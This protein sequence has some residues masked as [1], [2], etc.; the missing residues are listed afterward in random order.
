M[1][2]LLTLSILVTTLWSC[3]PSD[4]YQTKT[5]EEDGYTYEYVEAD[6][7]NTRI[8]T[9]D[10]GL[11]VYLSHYADAPRIQVYT[12][13]KAGGKNDPAENTGLAHYLEH[14]MFK[15]NNKFGTV[16][17]EEEVVM[18]DSIEAMFNHYATLTDSDERKAYY[19]KIDNYSNEAAKYAIPNEYDKMMALIGGKGL[20]AYTSND[21]TV[22]TVDIPSNELGRFLEIEG[23]RFRKIV[24]RL[25]HTELETVYEEKNRSLDS[26]FR[27]VYEALLSGLYKEHPYGTQTVIGTINHLKNPSIT[28][29]KKYF[30]TYYRP[31][32]VAI[33][34][35]GD[36]DYSETIIL[37][38]KNFGDWESN[39]DLPVWNKIEEDPITEPRI[40]EVYGPDAE[41]LQMGFRFNGTNSD[42]YIKV[43]LTDM[44]LNNAEAGL[45]DLNLKQKQT[46]LNAGSYVNNMNDYSIHTIYG[47]AKQ[48][49]SLEEVRDLILEQI[50]LLKAGE[51]DDWLLDAVITD[52]KKSAMNSLES[53]RSRANNMVMAFTNNI[54]WADY[55][56][57]I[58]KMEKVTK[59]ELVAFANEHYKDNYAI[60]YKRN[61]ED[62]NKQRVEK[63][64]ITKVP[65]NRDVKS[66]FHN[67]VT[68]MSVDKIKPVY[69][70][71]N[72][73][74][75]KNDVNKVKV[76]SKVNNENELF[77][78]TYL[79][80]LGKNADPKLGVAVQYLEFIGNEEFNAEELKKEFYKIGCSFSVYA[81]TERTY[82]TLSGLDENMEKA[83]TLFESLLANPTP[84]QEALDKL[85]DRQLKARSDAKKN[86]GNILFSGLRNYAKYGSDN[87]FTNVLSNVQLQELKAED[88][89]EI[90]KGITK[91]PH[92]ILYYGP[93]ATE[94]LNTFLG[95]YHKVPAEFD[96]VPQLKEFVELDIDQPL[97]YWTDYDMVQSEIVLQTKGIKYDANMT[98]QV[99][100]FNEYFGGGMN[101]IVFQEIREAQGLAYSVF[102]AYSQP[103]KTDRADYL[104]AYIGTQADKQAE[105]M[106]AMMDLINNMPESQDAFDIARKAI[107]NKIESERITK[108]STIWNYVNA[109][110]K[111]LD[112]DIRKDTYEQV[113]SMTFDDLK[114]FHEKYIKDKKYVTVLIGSRDKIDFEDLAKYGEVKEL[115]LDEIF[116]Y[117]EQ[118]YVDVET[119]T[120]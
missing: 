62:P 74:I 60:V 9:L 40:A 90:I 5:A 48:G 36:L 55:I 79:L 43:Q 94:G 105:A 49:Q 58:E 103:S 66:D 61:G 30:N 73:D 99:R 27:K 54:E 18:L 87:P 47:N 106:A 13:V 8:Y 32:N 101:S 68:E 25:F 86:K 57:K 82:V 51:F 14:M 59:E 22:Y 88:L 89:T 20:N 97:V 113:Q 114:T 76:I 52:F 107:L 3:S 78:L 100:M 46:V 29:I 111:G 53:N 120:E 95:E 35:S 1:K 38:E 10:N 75:T 16:N 41:F 7:T 108:S 11:K 67:A 98:P 17:Y 21:R 56:Q 72:N 63:P 117:E 26:D 34:M 31:N 24:N 96:P 81:A 65:L 44:I 104:F 109:Q 110:D 119:E 19:A 70:D 6:Q 12:P 64:Q 50:D 33:C 28:N 91:L 77:D 112:Y 23:S 15:G 93:R 92:R 118:I 84:D 4:P 80:D 37:I 102:S 42:E 71:Y 115:S 39:P 2:K 116:G 83:T 85:V 45:I 69:I